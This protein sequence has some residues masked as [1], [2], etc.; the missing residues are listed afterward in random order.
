MFY[1]LL[2]SCLQ[3]AYF[4]LRQFRFYDAH[5]CRFVG[6]D[7]NRNIFGC[8]RLGQRF[9]AFKHGKTPSLK[10]LFCVSES[11]FKCVA[12]ALTSGQVGKFNPKR[13]PLFAEYGRVE[14]FHKSISFFTVLPHALCVKRD[15]S[16]SA[17]AFLSNWRFAASGALARC[18]APEISVKPSATVL[19]ASF[20]SL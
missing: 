6:A 3:T 10:R 5:T 19:F 1:F 11:L 13:F 18:F 16:L 20:K 15:K 7:R 4:V 17:A 12:A 8:T 2:R 14:K 9:S